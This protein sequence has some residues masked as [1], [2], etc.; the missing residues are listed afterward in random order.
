[1]HKEIVQL[2]AEW[3]ALACSRNVLLKSNEKSGPEAAE[4]EAKQKELVWRDVYWLRLN[5]LPVFAYMWQRNSE[6]SL[7]ECEGDDINHI[8]VIERYQRLWNCLEQ[9]ASAT[10]PRGQKC[11]SDEEYEAALSPILL[12]HRMFQAA[13]ADDLYKRL[14]YPEPLWLDEHILA[15]FLNSPALD[16]LEQKMCLISEVQRFRDASYNAAQL[17]EFALDQMFKIWFRGIFIPR[18]GHMQAMYDL[19][20]DWSRSL[21]D[22]DDGMGGLEMSAAMWLH[23]RQTNGKFKIPSMLLHY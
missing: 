13:A 11:Q 9:E 19:V 7:E 5:R 1:M 12:K 8:M 16:T 23:E 15:Y 17:G 6:L 18:S 3:H 10:A 2:D 20:D 4:L 14:N 21:E 22:M